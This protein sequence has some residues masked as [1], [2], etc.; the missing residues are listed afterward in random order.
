MTTPTPPAPA[1][2]PA[3]QTQAREQPQGQPQSDAQRPPS[4][5]PFPW[6]YLPQKS[7]SVDVPG[8]GPSCSYCGS[9]PATAATV[10]GHQG[11]IVIM[12]WLK[13]RGMFCRSCGLATVRKMTG[14]SMVQGWWGAASMLIN[15]IVMLLNIRQWVKIKR[16]GEPV[17]GAPRRPA[18]PGRPLFLRP[19]ALG[20]LLP[21][22]IVGALWFFLHDDAEY[23][24]VG[25]CV[26][27]GGDP[28]FPDVSVVDCASP[29]AQYKVVDR[30]EGTTDTSLCG[31]HPGSVAAFSQEH[32]STRFVLCLGPNRGDAPDSGAAGSDS[33]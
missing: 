23:A 22:A 29:K 4:L 14:D 10:R 27:A 33:V 18:D 7:M 2:Q 1:P 16:L 31:A 19:V 20:L 11:M 12:K 17:P 6:P 24:A 3:T 8:Y 5:Y 21:F 32:G 25:D 13:V 9:V 28:L 30:L 26:H 15:P